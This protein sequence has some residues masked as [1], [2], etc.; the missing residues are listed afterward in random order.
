[1]TSRLIAALCCTS[2]LSAFS[3]FGVVYAQQTAQPGSSAGHLEEIVVTARKTEEKLQ[4][5]PVSITAFS[6]ARLDQANITTP[7]GLNGLVP[8]LVITQG[9]GYVTSINVAIRSIIQADNNLTSDAPIALY[10]N[11]VYNGRQMGG[12]C[13]VRPTLSQMRVRSRAT[14]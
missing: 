4:A 11:G 13:Q 6:A 7:T 8:N 14:A 2:A 1:M 9:S 10:F 5:V 3:S 12:C